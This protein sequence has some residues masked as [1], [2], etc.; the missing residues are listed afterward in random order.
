VISHF[1]KITSQALKDGITCT[2]RFTAA[3][4]PKINFRTEMGA[5]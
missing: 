2:R 3:L 1:L 5:G 4:L